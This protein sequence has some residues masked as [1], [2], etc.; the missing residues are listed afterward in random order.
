MRARPVQGAFEWLKSTI[1]K[2][3]MAFIILAVYI[4][5]IAFFTVP[6][7]I[8]E[9]KEKAWLARYEENVQNSKPLIAEEAERILADFTSSK[10]ALSLVADELKNSGI[11]YISSRFDFV[12]VIKAAQDDE[13]AYYKNEEINQVFPELWDTL[14]QLDFPCGDICDYGEYV[15]FDVRHID[16]SSNFHI[17]FSLLHGD[18]VQENEEI[19][20]HYVNYDRC[21][22]IDSQWILVWDIHVM[23]E[24][25]K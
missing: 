23:W 2:H 19:V 9:Q 25:Q 24:C 15:S 12:Y 3:R 10:D 8:K 11:T 22:Y 5:F 7:F 20:S 16:P 21:K 13:W 1:N 6:E 4:A 14:S 18:N 17:A